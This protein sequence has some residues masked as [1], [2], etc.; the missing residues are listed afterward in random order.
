[1]FLRIRPVFDLV[2]GILG[3][4]Y[5]HMQ[6][7]FCTICTDQL[8]FEYVFPDTSVF[9]PGYLQSDARSIWN[10]SYIPVCGNSCKSLLLVV[11][12]IV[13]VTVHFS[14]VFI[15]RLPATS[16][17]FY[18]LYPFPFYPKGTP[19]SVRAP[20]M[21]FPDGTQ[22]KYHVFYKTDNPICFSVLPF[23]S[24]PR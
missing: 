18:I 11:S 17:A 8:L 10:N 21:H 15:P 12:D 19:D 9:R 23:S 14:G 7:V 3:K 20:A 4:M 2:P 16:A 1:M 22:H 13:S 24:F 6:L 5:V